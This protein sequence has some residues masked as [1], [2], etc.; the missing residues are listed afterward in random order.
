MAAIDPSAP[1]EHNGVVNGDSPVRAT[2]K[3]IYDP[4]GLGVG[5]GSEGSDD[6]NYLKA[7]LEGNDDDEDESSDEEEKNGGPSDPTKSRKARKQAAAEQMMNALAADDSDD[8]MDD[9]SGDNGTLSK[10]NKGKAKANLTDEEDSDEVEADDSMEELVICTLDPAKVCQSILKFNTFAH[11]LPQ[12]YQQPLDLTICEDQR[13]FFKV[14]GTHAVYLTGNYV[15]PAERGSHPRHEIY[16]SE[17]EDEEYDLSPNEDELED[18]LEDEDESD[19]LDD[20]EDPRITEV[21][22]GDD[23]PPKLVKKEEPAKKGKNK[24][25]AEGSDEEPANIDDIMSKALKPAEPTSSEPKLSKK[26]L[27]KLKNNAGK[28]VEAAAENPNAKKVETAK[29]STNGKSDKKVQFAK[30][31]EQGPSGAGNG[32][33]SDVN[34]DSKKDDDKQKAS[35]GPKTVQGVQIDDKKLGKGPAAK[36]GNKVAMRYIGKLLDGK[37]FDGTASNFFCC[38]LRLT[39]QL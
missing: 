38:F 14:S 35:L 21:T 12:N 16:D 25:A 34:V 15:L 27:K 37:V 33:K 23:E 30:N 6:E 32:T 8:E 13:A 20:L 1:P 24:R 18:E 11:H 19:L 28:A 3:I 29:E 9:V 39:L 4:L 10:K 31:L 22:S 7:L 26:Q 2:L 5:E 36:K 17:D